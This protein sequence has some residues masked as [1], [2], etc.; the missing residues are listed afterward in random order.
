MEHDT[1]SF[2]L[3]LN[4]F[5]AVVLIAALAV[6]AFLLW[7]AFKPAPSVEVTPQSDSVV[8]YT[9]RFQRW[10]EGTSHL[11]QPGD[12]IA[13]NVKNYQIGQVVSAQAE[14][15]LV[16]VLDQEGRRYVQAELEGYEDVL[17]TIQAPCTVTD[18]AITVGGGFDIRVGNTVYL[19]GEGYM[20]S[21]PV[22]AL[23]QEVQG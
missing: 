3:R 19:K 11:I 5:D 6:G 18:G 8:R 1:H 12:Q 21:G 13:D 15:A 10:R 9:V 2:R 4:L 16:Q 23:E 22:V 17:V 14:P 7:N 20:G